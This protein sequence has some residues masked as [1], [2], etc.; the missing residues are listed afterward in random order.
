MREADFEA[1]RDIYNHYITETTISFETVA[2]TTSEMAH[3]LSEICAS[4]P[5]FVVQE[6]D[7][8]ILGYCYAHPWKERAAY[9]GTLE[10]SV[11]LHRDHTRRGLG[12]VLLHVLADECRARGFDSLIACITADNLPSRRLVERA[13]FTQAS[14]FVDVGRKFGRLLDVVDYQLLLNEA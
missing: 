2:L 13:G 10:A 11:Y 3:R 8:T 14:R 12:T 4:F 7:G 1:V 6:D 5:A 9:A